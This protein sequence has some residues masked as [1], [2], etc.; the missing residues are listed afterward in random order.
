MIKQ[1]FTFVQT[2]FLKKNMIFLK[3]FHIF[4]E[5]YIILH[6]FYMLQNIQKIIILLIKIT[7]QKLL[8]KLFS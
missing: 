3:I 6:E 2:I 4:Y 7:T 8:K 1:N 5:K